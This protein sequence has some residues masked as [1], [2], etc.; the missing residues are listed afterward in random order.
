MSDSLYVRRT[1][2]GERPGGPPRGLRILLDPVGVALDWP[3]AVVR[4]IDRGDTGTRGVRGCGWSVVLG[5]YPSR[6]RLVRV[7]N[8]FADRHRAAAGVISVEEAVLRIVAANPGRFP[9]TMRR[10]RRAE[11]RCETAGGGCARRGHAI[12]AGW[13]IAAVPLRAASP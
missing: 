4:C 11:A 2:A 5:G 3:Y 6:A 12:P 8:A 13:P 7:A 9:E 1:S 10:V